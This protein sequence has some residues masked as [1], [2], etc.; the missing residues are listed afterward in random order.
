MSGAG[1]VPHR[2]CMVASGECFMQG[3]CLQKC[4]PS[5][6]HGLSAE[7]LLI[8]AAQAQRKAVGQSSRIAAVIDQMVTDLRRGGR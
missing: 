4:N 2:Q 5:T 6:L 8:M 3:R 7:Q 1:F